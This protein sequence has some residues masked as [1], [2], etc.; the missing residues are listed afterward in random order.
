MAE[1][2]RR[3]IDA[4]FH[5]WNL[6]ENYYPWL[7]D[8]DRPS[9][10]RNFSAL[11]RNYLVSDLLRDIGALNV[12]A[13]VHIQAEHDHRD[14]VRETRWLQGVANDPASR[15]LPQAI[16]ADADFTSPDI[17]AVLA[18][19]CAFPNMRGVRH[20]LHRRLDETPPYDPLEDPVWV[21][22]FSLLAKYRLSFDLQVFPRQRD[23]TLRLIRANPAVS[24]ALTHAAMPLWSDAEN[25]ALWRRA[26]RAY[27]EL[28]NVAIKISGFGG[29][30]PDWSAASIDPLVSE[31]IRAF[32]PE[33]CMLASNFPVESLAKT[34]S[35]VWQIFA[36][37][38]ANYTENEN[39]LL[40]W[41]NA[42]RFYRIPTKTSRSDTGH[43]GA[44]D[45]V[46]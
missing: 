21:R 10:V 33:R 42:A 18:A 15:G 41:R 40:F 4:H 36:A 3:I 34:Y 16:I 11:R 12:I 22:N 35:E 32:G 13:G 14:P 19:H 37:T 9:L 29:I 39:E 25:V 1:S 2:G 17:D 43:S 38:F 44:G 45:H 8:G 5:L 23:G 20:A 28:P 24:F 31:I 7:S 6:D 27:A 26:I 46:L 30:D